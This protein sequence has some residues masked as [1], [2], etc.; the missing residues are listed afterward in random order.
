MENFSESQ[1]KQSFT[2]EEKSAN[3]KVNDSLKFVDDD[4][5]LAIPWKEKSLIYHVIT[6]EHELY[7]LSS[8]VFGINTS[9]FRTQFVAHT[10]AQ[11]NR[12]I[13]QMAQRLFWNQP[14]WT[15][16]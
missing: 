5:E 13:Y 7:E 15:I 9:P 11:N 4:Y 6:T 2:P 12:E 3:E 10:H 1:M 8:V 16:V 14:S